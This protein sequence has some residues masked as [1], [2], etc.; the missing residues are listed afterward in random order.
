MPDHQD[1]PLVFR[2]NSSALWNAPYVALLRYDKIVPFRSYDTSGRY[3]LFDMVSV[4]RR[5]THST[6]YSISFC[7]PRPTQ[8]F[9]GCRNT[10]ESVF[11]PI[12]PILHTLSATRQTGQASISM[13]HRKRSNT[14]YISM[15]QS[16]GMHPLQSLQRMTTQPRNCLLIPS[17]RLTIPPPRGI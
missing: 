13:L 8:K 6:R 9:S 11:E 4:E 10:R 3:R 16:P 14:H 15:H 17:G 5:G 7:L 2:R 12:R 1:I